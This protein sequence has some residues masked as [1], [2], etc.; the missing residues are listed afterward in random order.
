MDD[1]VYTLQ[2]MEAFCLGKLSEEQHLAFEQQLT[3]D[4]ALQREVSL[5]QSI[6]D[7]FSALAA[8]DLQLN[9]NNWAQSLGEQEDVELIEWYLRDEL[10]PVA[11]E[12]VENRRE[13]DTNFDALFQSQQNVL[14]GFEALQSDTFANQLQSWE[15]EAEEQTPVKSLNP[16][17]KRLSIAASITVLLGLGG[18]GYMKNQYSNRKLFASFYQSPNIGGTMGGRGLEGFKEQFSTAHRSLQR[19]QFE[20]AISAFSALDAILENLE[21]DPLAR[22]YYNSNV[23]WSL[24]LAQLGGGQV[25]DDF[26]IHLDQIAANESHEYQRQAQDLRQKLNSFWR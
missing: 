22:S 9:M 10:G 6:L 18:W 11:R 8:Q 1:K 4:D 5:I 13:S 2:E 23:E 17:I 26:L 19:G 14:E 16:W 15:K 7:G 3:V 21:L 24:I 12:Y 20:Q 25:D